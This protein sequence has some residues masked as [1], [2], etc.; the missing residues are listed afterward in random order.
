MKKNF[1]LS[2]LLFALLL[3][4]NVTKAQETVYS[5]D[6]SFQT[7]WTQSFSGG[8]ATF[9]NN[10][11]T[12]TANTTGTTT[13]GRKSVLP[14]S[15]FVADSV[16]V[17][18]DFNSSTLGFQVLLGT[19]PNRIQIL[20]ESSTQLRLAGE[21]ILSPANGAK[22]LTVNPGSWH[23]ITVKYK[24]SLSGTTATFTLNDGIA[25]ST[26]VVD[27]TLQASGYS[28][29]LNSI[30]LRAING[31]VLQVKNLK[32]IGTKVVSNSPVLYTDN[33]TFRNNWVQHFPANATVE[34][35]ADPE[36]TAN[37]I[38]KVSH[39]AAIAATTDS[40]TSALPVF[41]FTGTDFAINY[42][43]RT[44][45][46]RSN[47]AFGT[48]P[49]R[50]FVNSE[51]T[52]AI[53]TKM[54]LCGEATTLAYGAKTFLSATFNVWH[55]VSI[56]YNILN[57]TAVLIIDADKPSGATVTVD[58]KTQPTA[59]DLILNAMAIKT[60]NADV[61]EIKELKING[62][63]TSSASTPDGL[64]GLKAVVQNNKLKNMSITNDVL[65]FTMEIPNATPSKV[66]LYNLM[67][68]KVIEQVL[69]SGTSS[70]SIPLNGTD[71]GVYL[72]S[73][74]SAGSRSSQKIIVQ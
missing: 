58:L 61:F 36:N 53:P 46:N 62:I 37:N 65:S 9:A 70:Y 22:F 47:I 34:F 67:G 52:E 32:I 17:Q 29:S 50:L 16:E 42:K 43:F 6:F 55:T 41:N 23:T 11:I 72:L 13:V 28:F 21:A 27:L 1:T 5:D 18:F 71:N 25:T 59:Y 45:L 38:L 24:K 12:L 33:F 49:K 26:Q 48:T 74:E 63:G 57:K 4:S 3:I 64:T 2:T 20:K 7:N 8:T 39:I 69:S 54:R 10:A 19:T 56:N 60:S 31:E 35:V 15:I 68:R 66:F 73:I 44:K 40:L 14:S 51:F 30:D